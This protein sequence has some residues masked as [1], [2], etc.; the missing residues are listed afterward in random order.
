MIE[1][2]SNTSEPGP[3]IADGDAR[4]APNPVAPASSVLSTLNDDGS[5]RWLTPRLSLGRFLTARRLV[6][7]ALIAIFATLPLITVHGHPLIL[8]DI[9]SRRFY[10]FG[11]SFLPTDTLPLALLLVGVGL[12]IFWITALFGRVWCGWACPQ[13]VYM[14]FLFRPIE[15]LL[16]GSPGRSA[17]PP[18]WL[19][20]AAKPLK[21]LIYAVC[22]FVLAHM[23]LAYFVSWANLRLWVFGSP[24]DH[25]IGF[26]VVAFVTAA[27]LFDFGYFREQVCL[28]A[29]PYGRFQSVLLDRGS[30]IVSYDPKRGEPRGKKRSGAGSARSG[31][32]SLPVLAAPGDCVDCSMCVTTCP[33]GIDIRNGLQMECI[34]CAQC[35]D[36]CD[37]VMEKLQRPRGLIRYSS[38]TAMEGGRFKILRPR[39]VLYPAV[40]LGIA[41]LLTFVLL[42]ADA[43]DITVMRGFGQPYSAIPGEQVRN[44][45]RVKIVNRMDQPA[46][47]TLSVTGVEG[48]KLKSETSVV[49]VAPGQMLTVPAEIDAPIAAFHDGR[50]PI[51]V[52]VQ[53]P[54]KFE[55]R[56]PFMLLGPAKSE[57]KADE[58]RKE[59]RDHKEHDS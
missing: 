14:E 37:N 54:D 8:L 21:Y 55:S 51:T 26:G 50:A 7:Y 57:H 22:A 1:H 47:F 9:V 40:I 24:L 35:I 5:R 52:L 53:G 44:N 10:I 39:V 25:P 41:T 11:A 15:R 45:L 59:D 19:G 33:T 43:A 6:A 46:E 38:K 58:P 42:N 16:E 18:A 3:A 31:D 56:R 34:G 36:A 13:T 48:A 4:L 32:V 17:K 27:M 23:F 2:T 28:V 29:C 12:T 49:R 20:S 30:L